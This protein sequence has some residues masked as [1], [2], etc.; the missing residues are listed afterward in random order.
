V[1]ANFKQ[2]GGRLRAYRLGANLT[3][4]EVA[5]RLG[6]SR[7]ALYKYERGELIK[8]ETIER[9]S[10]L[11]GTSVTSLFGVGVEYFANAISFFERMRQI[12]AD[13]EHVITHFDSLSLHLHS[14]EYFGHLRQM[15]IE[16]LP[17]DAE[18]SAV[19]EIERAISILEERQAAV[20][21]RRPTILSI[22]GATQ[23]RRFLRSG[24]I[25]TYNLP[26]EELNRRRHLARREVEHAI[27]LMENE[28]IGVQAGVVEDTLPNQSFQ[29]FRQR[30]MTVLALSPFRLGELPN[31]RL[32]VASITAAEDATGL[33]ER[34]ADQL[35]HRAH[36][37]A[38]GADRLRE[39]LNEEF[40]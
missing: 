20:N 21:K 35:W 37:G 38:R 19:A 6:I 39:I 11:L 28:P 23:T 12:E 36:K 40:P 7:A 22:V 4:E 1:K 9:L 31:L 30:D 10:H 17:V 14:P 16:G 34:L 3:P 27:R 25:G 24:L 29:I 33:F 32:G 13:A 18:S 5:D 15:L 26:G 8:L 2:I